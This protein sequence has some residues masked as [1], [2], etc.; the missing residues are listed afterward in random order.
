MTARPILSHEL[1]NLA[2]ELAGL[3]AGRG[4]PK[5]IKLR[6]S[7]STS[8]YSLFHELTYS[9]AMLLCGDGPGAEV[10]RNRVVRWISHTDLLALTQAVLDPKKAAAA[11]LGQ[12]SPGLTQVADTFVDLQELRELADYDYSYDVS[13]SVAM[14][15]AQQASDAL[16]RAWDMWKN[17]DESYLRFLRLMVGAVRIAKNR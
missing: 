2:Y 8:Y 10:Q 4:K 15:A 1:R 17:D 3:G 7:I 16:E 14:D 11:A 13:R 5:T 6:R 12:P 9:A